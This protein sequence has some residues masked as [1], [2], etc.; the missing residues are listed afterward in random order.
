MIV[1]GEEERKETDADAGNHERD[2]VEVGQQEEAHGGAVADVLD[3]GRNGLAARLLDELARVVDRPLDVADVVGVARGGPP[4][5]AGGA[6][7][8][9]QFLQ[10]RQFRRVARLLAH[11]HQTLRYQALD[12]VL[13]RRRICPQ[14]QQQPACHSAFSTRYSVIEKRQAPLP[15]KRKPYSRCDEG[16]LYSTVKTTSR[17]TSFLRRYSRASHANG[18]SLLSSPLRFR[19]ASNGFSRQLTARPIATAATFKFP[20]TVGFQV[21]RAISPII[22]GFL[23]LPDPPVRTLPLN[24]N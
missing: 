15:R 4:A 21:P 1:E 20:S 6:R 12:H 10:P 17:P 5:L 23:Q 16:T 24:Q 3:D 11:R 2:V 14:Q 9:L 19:T 18:S 13:A 7:R 22:D 8:L